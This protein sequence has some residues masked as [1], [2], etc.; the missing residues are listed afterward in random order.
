M[1]NNW[2]PS[3]ISR[4]PLFHCVA[5]SIDRCRFIPHH[6]TMTKEEKKARI[7]EHN[8]EAC[9]RY[10]ANHPGRQ[11]ENSRRHRLSHLEQERK[12]KRDANQKVRDEQPL[13][14]RE[15][16]L[17]RYYGPGTFE[18][19]SKQIKKQEG[20]CAVCGQVPAKGLH[21]DHEHGT[22]RLRGGLCGS[23]NRALGLLKDNIALFEKAIAYLRAW[24][25]PK[26]A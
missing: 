16:H 24:E 1:R 19:Y 21:Q 6:A 25:L 15:Y 23:C 22:K 11:A 4:L 13:R 2:E 17:N 14:W 8:R 20:K 26:A 5:S 3:R 18:H 7:R 10:R 9:A 12:R